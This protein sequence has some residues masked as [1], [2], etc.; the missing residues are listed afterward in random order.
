MHSAPILP[1]AAALLPAIHSLRAAPR[2]PMRGDLVRI[3]LRKRLGRLSCTLIQLLSGAVGLPWLAMAGLAAH[4]LVPA[5][6]EEAAIGAVI[7]IPLG[8]AKVDDLELLHAIP[9]CHHTRKGGGGTGSIGV[10]S[11]EAT[12]QGIKDHQV[13]HD[14][15]QTKPIDFCCVRSQMRLLCY[16]VTYTVHLANAF[17]VLQGNFTPQKRRSSLAR[18]LLKGFRQF[19]AAGVS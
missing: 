13:S 16:A 3:H 1:P 10:R 11:G 12:P 2:P 7:R 19:P 18:Q 8:Q 14:S 4:F 17:P 5:L 9:G 15:P 6:L